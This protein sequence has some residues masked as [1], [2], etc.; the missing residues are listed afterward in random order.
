VC[1][2]FGASFKSESISGIVFGFGLFFF[3]EDS[4]LQ[5]DFCHDKI[6][7]TSWTHGSSKML[8]VCHLKLHTQRKKEET[9]I[10]YGF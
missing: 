9:G 5:P 4:K 6:T 7:I 2:K 8:S 10:V 1:I 3:T